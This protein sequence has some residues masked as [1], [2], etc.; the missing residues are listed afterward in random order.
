M[1]LAGGR[2]CVGASNTFAQ[3]FLILMLKRRLKMIDP[4][5]GKRVKE[6][7]AWQR[8]SA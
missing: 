3:F 8:K 7:S 6:S 2:T 4:S 1:D 5:C